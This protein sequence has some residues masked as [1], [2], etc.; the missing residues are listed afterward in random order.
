[1]SSIVELKVDQK[2]IDTHCKL[3]GKYQEISN[4]INRLKKL[5]TDMRRKIDLVLHKYGKKVT[6]YNKLQRR[7]K[8]YI[9]YQANG[10]SA[11]ILFVTTNRVRVSDLP[12]EIRATY[13]YDSTS[14]RLTIKN[15]KGESFIDLEDDEELGI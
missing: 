11:S 3:F 1:M 9:E 4:E 8:S 7:D 15:E 13:S 2:L 12:E 5:Q 6:H 14:E 10:L